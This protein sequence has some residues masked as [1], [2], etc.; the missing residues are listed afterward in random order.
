[1]PATAAAASRGCKRGGTWSETFEPNL[2]SEEQTASGIALP[3]RQGV[4]DVH[5]AQHG[6]V[7]LAADVGAQRLY[8]SAL[9]SSRLLRLE[10]ATTVPTFIC[11]TATSRPASWLR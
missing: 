5:I 11:G 10:A 4:A 1:M 9:T 6:V 7:V 3:K 8:G 2:P